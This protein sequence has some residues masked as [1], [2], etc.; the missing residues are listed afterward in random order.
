MSTYTCTQ[1]QNLRSQFQ[2]KCG[3]QAKSASRMTKPCWHRVQKQNTNILQF[4]CLS[5]DFK[6][7]KKTHF[8]GIHWYILKKAPGISTPKLPKFMLSYS[9]KF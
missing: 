5:K 1:I 2:T 6:A 9:V 3:W 8:L 4:A 7:G